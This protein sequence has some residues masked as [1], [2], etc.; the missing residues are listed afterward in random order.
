MT[1]ASSIGGKVGL[2]TGALEAV[3][4]ARLAE[5]AAQIE[6]LGYGALWYGEAWGRE[7]F[8]Q[9]AILLSGTSRLVVGTGIANIY[10]RDAAASANGG[11]AL[12]AAYDNR[13]VLGLGVSH[14]PL[15]ERMRGH[16]YASPIETMAAYLQAMD[17]VPYMSSGPSDQ[18]PR[19]LAALGPK[20]LTLAATAADGAH[21][22]LVTPEHT[23]SA[24]S[25]MGEGPLLIV[26]QAVALVDD[27][28]EFV[29]R[30]HEHLNIYTGLPNYK[31]SW[32]RQGFTDDDFGRGGSRRLKD[33]MVVWG[34]E[35]K[36]KARVQEHLDAGADQVL[37]Q[38]L[39]ADLGEVPMD[40]WARIAPAV[41]SV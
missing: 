17:T 27:E 40:D 20:M 32:K 25:T 9:A 18:A 31:N 1:T 7:A 22:Y 38:V 37:L 12:R 24:R 35:A 21:P 8:T 3:E 11:R 30:A 16:E 41:L 19:V 34:D 36:V 4:P 15:V 33:A 6:A 2:W 5:T 28:D 39:G 10:A 13:F 26:E 14:K 29:R 23:A